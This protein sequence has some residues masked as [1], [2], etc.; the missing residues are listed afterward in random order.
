MKN[1][2]ICTAIMLLITI[3][4]A[5]LNSVWPSLWCLLATVI[6][7]LLLIGSSK[8][9]RSYASMYMIICTYVLN[10]VAVFRLATEA[11]ISV[12]T[13]FDKVVSTR[14]HIV[15]VTSLGLLS[16]YFLGLMSS[17][18]C[19]ILYPNQKKLNYN[20]NE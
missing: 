2:K 16:I 7:Q 15:L 10:S 11:M 12:Y 17:Y 6:C 13:F 3:A 5:I 4:V 1:N 18:L 20:Q 19:F 9:L 8:M 14:Y